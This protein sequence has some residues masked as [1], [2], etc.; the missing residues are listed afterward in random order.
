LWEKI[1]SWNW[2][3]E[4]AD[5]YATWQGETVKTLVYEAEAIRKGTTDGRIMSKEFEAL[6]MLIELR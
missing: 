1:P 3:V 2:N 6:Q 5:N 4:F